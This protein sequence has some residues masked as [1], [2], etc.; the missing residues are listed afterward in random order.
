MVC[1][2]PSIRINKVI[3]VANNIVLETLS[4]NTTVSTLHVA[5]NLCSRP[6]PLYDERHENS[7]IPTWNWQQ[8]AFLGCRSTISPRLY[9]LLE[10]KL[11][12]ISA[13][14]PG[15]PIWTGLLMKWETAMSLQYWFQSTM[16][17]SLSIC[18]S[19]WASATDTLLD[20]P[21]LL[22]HR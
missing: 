10:N 19:C 5:P 22:H 16:E 18:Y 8:K 21:V 17:C 14:C 4:S 6:D 11:S 9:F 13:I 12:S 2:H 7:G 20:F 1:C 3:L 15:P